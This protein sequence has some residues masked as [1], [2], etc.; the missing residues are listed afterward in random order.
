M[1]G[2]ERDA[3]LDA[4]GDAAAVAAQHAR[5]E[6]EVAVAGRAGEQVRDGGDA[7]AIAGGGL[8]GRIGLHHA[9][10]IPRK[11]RQ[12]LRFVCTRNWT[13]SMLRDPSSGKAT[14]MC[15]TLPSADRLL[16]SR[17]PKPTSLSRPR[18]SLGPKRRFAPGPADVEEHGRADVSQLPQRVA[19]RRIAVRGSGAPWRCR[20]GNAA[21]SR[22]GP[23]RRRGSAHGPHRGRGRCRR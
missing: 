7:I 6:R 16:A 14:S 5:L 8:C 15:T 3:V 4:V 13:S 22:A 21:D 23:C 9:A 19:S 10:I 2:E 17:S 20:P 1:Q 11:R 12:K 18:F